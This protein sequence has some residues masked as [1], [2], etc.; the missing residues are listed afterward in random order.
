MIVVARNNGPLCDNYDGHKE[1]TGLLEGREYKVISWSYNKEI[2]NGRRFTET[3]I[4][5]GLKGSGYFAN[6]KE[7]RFFIKVIFLQYFFIILKNYCYNST[8]KIKFIFVN[9]FNPKINF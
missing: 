7:P 9:K 4:D 2:H 6:I 1:R 3:D 5:S 8:K